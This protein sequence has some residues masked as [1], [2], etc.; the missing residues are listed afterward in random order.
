MLSHT[1]QIK[2]KNHAQTIAKLLD[3]TIISDKESKSIDI[4]A[5]FTQLLHLAF[6]CKQNDGEI[7]FIGNGASA[8]IASHC[9][10]DIFK[11][12]KIRTRVFTDSALI[13]AMGNDISFDQVY[14]TPIA[15]TMR[16]KDIL[17]AISSS[18]ASTN[19]I[20][21]V[22]AAHTCKGTIVTLS[23]FKE[24]NPLRQMGNLNFYLPAQTY[25]NAETCHTALLHYWTD[26]ITSN[27]SE[28]L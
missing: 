21:A 6:A 4:D 22:K 19:I 18:G 20:E 11:N 25:G 8:A 1:F 26:N 27:V 5:G 28:N 15:M 7:I 24:D 13:T 14:A 17:V 12:A 2:W 10:A 3:S 16:E 9:A 23:A